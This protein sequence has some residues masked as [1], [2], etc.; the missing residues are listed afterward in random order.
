MKFAKNYIYI[1]LFIFILIPPHLLSNNLKA[2]TVQNIV[3]QEK[4]DDLESYIQFNIDEQFSSLSWLNQNHH[5]N[6]WYDNSDE[7]PWFL[8]YSLKFPNNGSL[9][10]IY[11]IDLATN[12]NRTE[13]EE[14]MVY[15]QLRFRLGKSFELSLLIKHRNFIA[16]PP[17]DKPFLNFPSP[18]SMALVPS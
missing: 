7:S 2:I 11:D 16:F 17:C 1:Y 10:N 14:W 5:L 12:Q 18:P 3:A 6:T 8:S 9:N 15:E 13:V 4:V